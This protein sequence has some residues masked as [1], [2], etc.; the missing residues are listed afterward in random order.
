MSATIQAVE[1]RSTR[2][3]RAIA[4]SAL[5]GYGIATAPM[6]GLPDFL[7]IGA[8]RGATTSLWNHIVGHPNVL[9]LFPSRQRIKGTSFLT[10]NFGEGPAWYRSHFATEAYRWVRRQRDGVRPLMGEATPYYL[11]HPLAPE[12]AAAVAP[13]AKLVAIL[14][15]P[16]DRAY[17]HYRERARHGVETLAFEEA[18]T[19]EEARLEGEEARIIEERGYASYAHEHLSYAAQGRYAPMLER[20]FAFFPRDHVL[21]LLNDDFDRDR[22]GE[23]RRAFSFLGLPL[24]EPP[25]LERY[26]FHPDPPM[27]PETRARLLE[28]F[29][30]DNGRLEALLGF[31][32]RAWSA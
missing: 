22:D 15:N 10:T 31:S 29:R 12:R 4:K 8:K 26:N 18:L 3:S 17:S 21:I 14:R 25:R 9:P 7:I 11:F 23:L 1:G 20:W 30:E 5:R 24:W 16:V 32:L 6:R 19:A 27:A 28:A 2:S 13:E